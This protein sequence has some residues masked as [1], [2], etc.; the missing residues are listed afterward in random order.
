MHAAGQEEIVKGIDYRVAPHFHTILK[1]EVWQGS[2]G[3]HFNV[4]GVIL[5]YNKV[6]ILH[7]CTELVISALTDSVTN[8]V[9]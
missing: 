9:N 3:H 1:P 2:H 5:L 4:I 7:Q 8:L 6:G